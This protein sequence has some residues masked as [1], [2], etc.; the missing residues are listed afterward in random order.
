MINALKKSW[1]PFSVE[2]WH[3]LSGISTKYEPMMRNAFLRATSGRRQ[4]DTLELRTVITRILAETCDTT[5]EVYG[6]V[7]NPNSDIYTDTIDSL[8]ES[9]H[10]VMESKRATDAVR[11]IL[12]RDLTLAARRRRLDTYGLDVRSALSI[13]R[14]WQE[15]RP[16]REI[17]QARSTAVL[18]RGNMIALTET[19]RAVNQSVQAL[20]LDNYPPIEKARRPRPKV[21]YIGTSRRRVMSAPHKTWLT[22]RDDRVCKYCLPL[23][24]ITAR[25]DAE[26]ETKYGVFETP[27]IHPRCRCFM[28]FG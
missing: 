21:V 23:D 18:S 13:E 8:L 9:F 16:V 17:E 28:V 24:G 12:P 19:N 5:A 11:L 15:G 2:E 20:W 4:I 27:P 10:R 22:R 7:F 26:F 3:R 6:L 1:T 14:M 25:I